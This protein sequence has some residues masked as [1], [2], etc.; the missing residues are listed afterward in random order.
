MLEDLH[1]RYKAEYQ[2]LAPWNNT[3]ITKSGGKEITTV[4]YFNG[5]S[6]KVFFPICYLLI[7]Y[8]ARFLVFSELYFL[9]VAVRQLVSPAAA[10]NVD[11]RPSRDV[12]THPSSERV[13]VTLLL[14]FLGT[15]PD[16][17]SVYVWLLPS[18]LFRQWRVF[19]V[20]QSKNFTK[21]WI[22][23][24]CGR[25]DVLCHKNEKY[26]N[27]AGSMCFVEQMYKHIIPSYGQ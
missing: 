22:M 9:R 26:I 13:Y 10:A 12:S 27:M 20:I 14:Y 17:T 4:S 5:I 16:T 19:C 25:Y 6:M 24:S 21:I 7:L 18:L 23:N 8:W 11:L 15:W 3:A 2:T 1:L